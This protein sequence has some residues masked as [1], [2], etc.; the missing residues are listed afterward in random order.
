M[1]EIK[2]NEMKYGRGII[3]LCEKP[4][5]LWCDRE[6]SWKDDS[7]YLPGE[8]NLKSLRLNPPTI[9]WKEMYRKEG[10]KGDVKEVRLPTTVEEHFWGKYSHRRYD[11]AEYF[12]AHDDA[13]VSNGI[14]QGV[15]WWW[16]KVFVPKKWEVNRLWIKFPGARLRAEVYLNEQLVGYNIIAETP[17]FITFLPP[18]IYF[19]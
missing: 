9:G 8:L 5:S 15:S 17:I 1:T 2:V 11:K 3:N 12:F 6:A 13:E 4:W 10:I 7:V 19:I 14:Y 16:R 18:L